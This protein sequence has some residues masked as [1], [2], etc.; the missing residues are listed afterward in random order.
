MEEEGGGEWREGGRGVEGVEGGEER[1]VR[2]G[3][4]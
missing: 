2:E 1:R 3:D 4:E